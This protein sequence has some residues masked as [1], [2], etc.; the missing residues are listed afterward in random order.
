VQMQNRRVRTHC[1]E[2]HPYSGENLNIRRD[3]TQKCRACAR[4]RDRR[5]RAA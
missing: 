3:G 2:G 4:I 5:R 1:P